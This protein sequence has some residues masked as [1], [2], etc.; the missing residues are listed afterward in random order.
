MSAPARPCPC[1][2][3]ARQP[4]IRGNVVRWYCHCGR[5]LVTVTR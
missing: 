2:N 1:G 5:F 4:K 3:T